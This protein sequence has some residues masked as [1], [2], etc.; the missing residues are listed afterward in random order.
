M[1]IVV[2]GERYYIVLYRDRHEKALATSEK[3]GGRVMLNEQKC[4][5]IIKTSRDGFHRIE[6]PSERMIAL[7][8]MLWEM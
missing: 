7:Y 8:K 3:F 5:E 4:F 2:D 6:E 1:G